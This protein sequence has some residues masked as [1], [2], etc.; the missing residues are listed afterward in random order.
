MYML[1]P[2][3]STQ[4][5][6]RRLLIYLLS[7][8]SYFPEVHQ[9]L[10]IF[11]AGRC[12]SSHHIFLPPGLDINASPTST[13]CHTDIL[14]GQPP[15]HH[16]INRTD[17]NHGGIVTPPA[18]HIDQ[19][20]PSEVPP[21]L[22]SSSPNLVV[23][24]QSE[25]SVRPESLI[26]HNN[27]QVA[28]GHAAD[29]TQASQ[30]STLPLPLSTCNPPSSLPPSDI[31]HTTEA[32]IYAYL[33]HQ[34]PTESQ[35]REVILSQRGYQIHEVTVGAVYKQYLQHRIILNVCPAL[36]LDHT[37]PTRSSRLL[38][39]QGLAVNLTV[40]QVIHWSGRSPNTYRNRK[41]LME[42]LH[43]TLQVIRLDTP[44]S[45]L[46]IRYSNLLVFCYTPDSLQV[47]HITPSLS[48]TFD[49]LSRSLQ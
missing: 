12:P 30:P 32:T 44:D 14:L 17:G 19:L 15:D 33:T 36:G 31:I 41:T 39:I 40:E 35:W 8:D 11:W 3:V 38:E 43:S 21:T 24:G 47:Q 18:S 42:K 49:E 46:H 48:W 25:S 10:Y 2:T 22:S 16:A 20:F 23:A 27:V 5:L 26:S 34:F 45:P 37:K 7:Y 4:Y 1:V 13:P 6:V 28:L 9:A 29:C